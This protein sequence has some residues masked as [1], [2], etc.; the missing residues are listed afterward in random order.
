MLEWR[1]S[2][3]P[4]FKDLFVIEHEVNEELGYVTVSF[5]G[6]LV[7]DEM[8]G[9]EARLL[10]DARVEK[11]MRRIYDLSG[12]QLDLNTSQLVQMVEICRDWQIPDETR[13]AMIGSPQ[14]MSTINLFV[15]H[16]SNQ[17]LYACRTL[18]QATRWLNESELPDLAGDDR[19]K[20]IV[21]RGTLTLDDIL[22]A[23]REWYSDEHFDAAK[24]VLWDLRDTSAGSSITEMRERVPSI[25]SASK[26]AE[27]SGKTSIL[28][29]SHLMELMVKKLI[30]R[31]DWRDASR[32]FTKEEDALSWI[33]S[34]A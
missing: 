10:E 11:S 34:D 25:V 19:Y 22:R 24:P 15:T 7:L 30:Q 21:L 9:C 28:V 20:L 23:Q 17:A 14:N 26:G 29:N 13:V 5:A 8:R 2:E 31:G 33:A 6:D 12:V 32:L 4:G 16:F 27:R 18:Q 1:P 3:S